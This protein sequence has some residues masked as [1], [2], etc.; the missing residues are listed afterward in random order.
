MPEHGFPAP[1]HQALFVILSGPSGAGKSTLMRRFIAAHP[2][3]VRCLSVTTRP[4]RGEE[5]DGVDYLFVTPEEFHRRTAAGA[6][7]ETAQVFGTHHYGTPRAFVDEQLAAGRSVIKEVDVQGAAT[8]RR[9]FPAAVQVFVTPSSRNEI[10]R[11]LRG[12]GT[13]D[14]AVIARRLAEAE[15]ELA[16]WRDYD[17]L[18]INDDLDRALAHL[19]AIVA[20]EQLRIRQTSPEVRKSG[21]PEV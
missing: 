1:D 16:R 8:I 20:A 12:R 18:V 9:T 17:Y 10:E 6:W 21:S 2:G 13:D 7:L 14:E 3:F 4:P 11:R 19:A 15:R 5:R